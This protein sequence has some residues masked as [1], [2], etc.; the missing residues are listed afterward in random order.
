MAVIVFKRVADFGGDVLGGAKVQVQSARAWIAANNPK[1]ATQVADTALNL[2]PDAPKALVTRAQALA[3]QGAYWEASDDLSLVLYADPQNVEA[4][5]MRGAAYRQL[6]AADLA[7]DDLNRAL[8]LAPNHPEGLLERG[9]V[10][11]LS[12]DNAKARADWKHLIERHPDT[13]AARAARANVHKLD[14]GLN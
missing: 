8:Q 13:Q 12:Q 6:D 4:L 14:S 11:R 3:L 2:T 10:Y 5:V 9:I 1:R 7:L